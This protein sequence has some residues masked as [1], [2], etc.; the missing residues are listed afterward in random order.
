MPTPTDTT[1][2][3]PP[4]PSPGPLP[5]IMQGLCLA[6]ALLFSAALTR[7]VLRAGAAGD[8]AALV[9]LA[10]AGVLAAIFFG[11]TYRL[12]HG[13]RR[14]EILTRGSA[15]ALQVLGLTTAAMGMT[16]ALAGNWLAERLA[17]D[18]ARFSGGPGLS[19]LLL[20]LLSAVIF[21]VGRA[22]A[23]AAELADDSGHIV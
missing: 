18:L 7:L 3:L 4:L 21:A 15:L 17:L 2:H 22:M 11:A 13:F 9:V 8:L 14:G 19:D 5:V 23:H 1:N 12:F 16:R 10:P 6:G 20:V